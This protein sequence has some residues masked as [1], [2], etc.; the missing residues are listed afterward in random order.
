LA[1][2]I[3]DPAGI[4]S[5]SPAAREPCSRLR[6]A[7]VAQYTGTCRADEASYRETVLTAFQQVQDELATLRVL[8]QELARQQAAVAAAR[9]YLGI[10]TAR[11]RTGIDPYLNV[12][13]AEQTLG[14][15]RR[16]SPCG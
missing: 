12:M 13:T 9:R 5:T 11:Y 14:I 4:L 7:T 6:R 2:G 1:G 16:S 10:A 15:S 8:S 3:S